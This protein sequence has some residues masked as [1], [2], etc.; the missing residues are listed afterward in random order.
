MSVSH[1]STTVLFWWPTTA[2]TRNILGQTCELFLVIDASDKYRTDHSQYAPG[3]PIE[4]VPFA[5][6]KVLRNLHHVLGSPNATLR[7][8]KA[9]AGPVV[10]DNGNFVIDAPFPREIM[11]DP[12]PI[13]TKIKMLTGVVEVGIFCHMAQAAYFGNEVS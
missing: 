6:A 5:Y 4:V 13:M 10:S 9:K 1:R 7:M 8:A 11:I 3:V 2:K 12:F